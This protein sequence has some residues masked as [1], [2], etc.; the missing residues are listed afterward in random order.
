MQEAGSSGDLQ[1]PQADIAFVGSAIDDRGARAIEFLR[2]LGL[3]VLPL[4][5]DE[6]SFSIS[7]DKE[8]IGAD[9]IDEALKPFIKA[10]IVLEATTLGVAEILLCCRGLRGLGAGSLAFTYVEPQRYLAQPRRDL[11]HKRDFE[12]STAFPGFRPI[13]GF[14][15]NLA[16]PRPS[17]GFFFLGYEDR[18][19]DRALED[20]QM[21]DGSRSSVVF[22]VPAF[23]PGW[24][25]NAFSR[26]LRVLRDKGIR[27]EI[28]FC[29]AENPLAAFQLIEHAYASLLDTE[30]L[31]VAPLGTKPASI[32]VAL[33]C[34]D[35]DD[36]G[37]LYDHP[38]RRP[39][40][41]EDVARWHLYQVSF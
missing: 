41:S 39:R 35:K 21:I 32:A 3:T 37:V 10:S 23:S 14:V 20:H 17:K 25:M 33:F 16:D 28:S 2:G 36:V 27:P 26:N 34:S 12:L 6:E 18:R 31:F 22:G 4:S 24:E 30:R 5:Y 11:L 7:I 19:L 9:D 40:R 38:K 8:T 15:I 13:P 29:G 1:M